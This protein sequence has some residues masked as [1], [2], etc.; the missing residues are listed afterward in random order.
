[1][2]NRAAPTRQ[3]PHEWRSFCTNCVRLVD[4]LGNALVQDLE[5]FAQHWAF[6]VPESPAIRA[7]LA[8]MLG[9][10]YR[11][12]WTAVPQIRATLGL[13]GEA[14]AQAYRRQ[15][16]ED[17]AG[18]YAARIGLAD[19]F[20]AAWGALSARVDALPPFSLAFLLT[21]A[22]G[23]SQAFLALPM[24]VAGPLA[25]VDRGMLLVGGGCNFPD[26]MPWAG[27]KKKYYN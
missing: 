23:F 24:G 3:K 14:V 21:L 22:F 19:Q 20:R 18:I 8:R 15:Y 25:G 9:R 13:D 4:L 16:R 10:K 26:S 27:G 5:R 1:V 6:L 17:L 2:P 12:T 11:F 7:T